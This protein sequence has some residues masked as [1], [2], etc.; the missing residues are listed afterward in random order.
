METLEE[1]TTEMVGHICDN[2]CRHPRD[3]KRLG[4]SQDMLDVICSECKMGQ[5]R[6]DIL[7]AG[8]EFDRIYL[9]KCQEQSDFKKKIVETLESKIKEAERLM[10]SKPHDILDKIANDT[11]ESFI[12]AY[13]ECIDLIKAGD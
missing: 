1:L 8:K 2:L 11:A 6:S 3:T 10:V 4:V 7:N 5:F 13:Q 12:S 9:K